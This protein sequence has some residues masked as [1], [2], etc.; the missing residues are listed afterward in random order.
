LWN[1]QYRRDIGH[2]LIESDF[3]RVEVLGL[4]GLW[5]NQEHALWEAIT[6]WKLYI[7]QSSLTELVLL[8]MD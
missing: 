7:P 3:A 8:R 1:A 6:A 4:T 5:A 2:R